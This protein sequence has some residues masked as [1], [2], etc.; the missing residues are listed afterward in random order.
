MTALDGEV[1]NRRRGGRLYKVIGAIVVILV[2]LAVLAPLWLGG[3]KPR[4]RV[5]EVRPEVLQEP[6]GDTGT[7]DK[8]QP[9]AG[10]PAA[11][12]DAPPEGSG[13]GTAWWRK[14]TGAEAEKEGGEG[15]TEDSAAGAKPKAKD[16]AEAE[17]PAGD[18][19]SRKADKESG[20]EEGSKAADGDRP[21]RDASGEETAAGSGDQAAAGDSGAQSEN[22]A[23]SGGSGEAATPE[24]P[25]WSVM[26]GSFRDPANARKLRDELRQK[27]FDVAVVAARVRG[28]RWNRVL[29]GRSDT[30]SGAQKLVPRLKKAGYGDLLVMKT[31]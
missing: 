31:E 19:T 5:V 24:G 30:R 1:G 27:G 23:P 20:A 28:Q 29:A 9:A 26:V 14:E 8:A 25:Y 22:A 16:S 2:I 12:A 21:E 17:A 10:Q 15:E 7:A 18:G 3:E 11:D 4:S 13:G 6:S